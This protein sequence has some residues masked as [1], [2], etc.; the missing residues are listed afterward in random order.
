M[1]YYDNHRRSRDDDRTDRERPR[2]RR[3]FDKYRVIGFLLMFLG[4]SILVLGIF[5]IGWTASRYG[6]NCLPDPSGVYA[7]LCNGNHIFVYIGSAL[8]GGAML[9][10]AAFLALGI[11]PD[12]AHHHRAHKQ[13]LFLIGFDLV[14]I[15]PAITVLNALEVYFG[16]SVYWMYATNGSITAYDQLQFGLPVAICILAGVAFMIILFFAVFMFCCSDD[17]R[18]YGYGGRKV[19]DE[20]SVRDRRTQDPYRH[21]YRG[22]AYNGGY[23]GY[24][25]RYYYN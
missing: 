1:D 4:I 18:T 11:H 12:K 5:D 13:F 9:I 17:Y 21:Y 24:G 16:I 2:R 14:L 25:K 19:Y 8:W 7:G 6:N 3:R 20:D 23:G 10:F 15:T 22:H